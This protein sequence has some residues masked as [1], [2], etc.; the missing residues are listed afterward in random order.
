MRIFRYLNSTN[1][2]KINVYN[3]IIVMKIMDNK[4]LLKS[5]L[6]LLIFCSA[7]LYAQNARNTYVSFTTSA[8]G[9]NK[10]A[11]EELIKAIN[12]YRSDNQ[13]WNTGVTQLEF[14]LGGVTESE[15]GLLDLPIN[16]DL[17]FSAGETARKF[18]DGTYPVWEHDINGEGATMRAIKDGWAPSMNKLF[19]ANE[20]PVFTMLSENLYNGSYDYSWQKVLTGWQQSP[21]HNTT[22][23]SRG[24]V[25]IGCGCSDTKEDE[26]TRSSY[27]VLLVE[28]EDAASESDDVMRQYFKRGT[29]YRVKDNMK[30]ADITKYKANEIYEFI[31]AGLQKIRD[32]K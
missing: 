8:S 3:V 15:R 17:M 24:A 30:N 19:N 26:P 27:W 11:V 31:P 5:V 22:I 4:N 16:K 9:C 18:A 14:T 12:K 23:L 29:F 2:I 21:G 7:S 10:Q 20:Q 6:T 25:S 1:N 32:E 13:N 28:L